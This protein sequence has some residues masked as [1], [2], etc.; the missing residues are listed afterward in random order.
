MFQKKPNA[1]WAAWCASPCHSFSCTGVQ[2]RCLWW[3]WRLLLSLCHCGSSDPFGAI[4]TLCVQLRSFRFFR[5]DC[6]TACVLVPLRHVTAASAG[7]HSRCTSGLTARIQPPIRICCK[8]PA[9]YKDPGTVPLM[10][11]CCEDPATN[12]ESVAVLLLWRILQCHCC[13]GAYSVITAV[14]ATRAAVRIQCVEVEQRQAGEGSGSSTFTCAGEKCG[15][16]SSCA[17]EMCGVCCRV[18]EKCV[19]CVI[20]CGRTVCVCVCVIHLHTCR[21]RKVCELK[22]RHEAGSALSGCAIC[23]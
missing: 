16:V 1:T 6:A 21:R 4:V 17:G 9:T 18:R 19:K 2:A 8:D 20:V 23:P 11:Q 22:P 7:C 10:W 14:T 5:C 12:Q 3:R 13:G 15:S